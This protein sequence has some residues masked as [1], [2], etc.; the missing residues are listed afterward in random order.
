MGVTL[1]TLSPSDFVGSKV[2][3]PLM[4]SFFCFAGNAA[5]IKTIV[6]KPFSKNVAGCLCICFCFLQQVQE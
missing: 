6:L 4:V 1:G 5:K 2:K 3:R